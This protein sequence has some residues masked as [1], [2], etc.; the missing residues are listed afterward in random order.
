MDNSASHKRFE[1]L[2]DL[3]EVEQAEWREEEFDDD[4]IERAALGL[5]P[6]V[7]DDLS[8]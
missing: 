7:G 8:L 5:G 6:C 4:T 3:V 2:L 1:S